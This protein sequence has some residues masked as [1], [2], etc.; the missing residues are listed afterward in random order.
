MVQRGGIVGALL[1]WHQH[2]GL[3]WVLCIVARAQKLLDRLLC[4]P[5]FAL[6]DHGCQ[7]G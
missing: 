6:E 1:L 4:F 5:L 2:R 3:Q 7:Q